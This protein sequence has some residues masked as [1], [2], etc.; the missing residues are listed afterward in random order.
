MVASDFRPEVEIRPFRACAMKNTPYNAYLWPNG[1]N[2]RILK[3]IGVE[4]H[5][6]D[7]RFWTGSGNI[8]LSFMRHA[9][10]HNYRNS[11]FIVDVAMG[12]IPRSTE[13]ISSLKCYSGLL[14]SF[15]FLQY[16]SSFIPTATVSYVVWLKVPQYSL[17]FNPNCHS[18][19]VLS[20]QLCQ[21]PTELYSNCL[22][23]LLVSSDVHG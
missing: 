21:H 13:R 5:D 11:S 18:T 15:H 19:V 17:P 8:A 16:F 2:F 20:S 1:R 3:E 22:S 14:V 10:G 9:S 12:Q 6:G 23:S 4:E 7:V